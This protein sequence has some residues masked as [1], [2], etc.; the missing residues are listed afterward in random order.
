MAMM[1]NSGHTPGPATGRRQFLA[2]LAALPFAL[3]ACTATSSAPP[4]APATG[5]PVRIAHTF[6]ATTIET[7]P[8]HIVTVGVASADICVALGQAPVGMP[9]TNSTPWFNTA[10]RAMDGPAPFLFDDADGIPV[11]VIKTLTPDLILAVNSSLSRKD[12]DNLSAIAPVVAYP[13]GPME[14]PWRTSLAMIGQALGRRDAAEALAHTTEDLIRS[15]VADYPGLK[16]STVLFAG[17]SSAVGAVLQVY[18]ETSIAMH[19]LEEFGL[20]PSPALK[21]VA[22]QGGARV[23]G[24]DHSVI[25]WPQSRSS[26]LAAQVFIASAEQSELTAIRSRGVLADVPATKSNSLYYVAGSE[27]LSLRTGSPLGVAWAGHNVVPELAKMAYYARHG[28]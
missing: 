23:N 8:L 19:V 20:T 5:F 13:E 27:S 25:L 26:E 4:S 2:A 16:K 24:A 6:G 18:G 12:Y 7:A 21:K 22:A 3:S 15:S 11:D 28:A 17:V 14:T 10:L 9:A 1:N